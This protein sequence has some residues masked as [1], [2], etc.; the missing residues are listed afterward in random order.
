MKLRSILAVAMLCGLAACETSTSTTSAAPGAVGSACCKGKPA[1]DP[2]CCLTQ[3][4]AGD[5]AK[6][7]DKSACTAT[8][9][10]APA[11]CPVTGQP[12][13]SDAAP[14]AVSGTSDCSAKKASGC[15]AKKANSN[16]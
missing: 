6:C 12:V 16:G 10:S 2:N 4:K 8:A 3:G 11:T 9:A 1:G 7:G 14:G 13:K 5:P 15:C